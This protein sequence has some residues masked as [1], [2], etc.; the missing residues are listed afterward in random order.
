[1]PFLRVVDDVVRASDRT[2][3]T[4]LVLHAGHLGARVLGDRDG[5]G[6]HTSRRTDDQDLVPRSTWP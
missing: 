2:M 6:S 1:V 3:S 4:F 5:E